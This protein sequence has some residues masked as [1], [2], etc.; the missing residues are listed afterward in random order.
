MDALHVTWVA[1]LDI[2]QSSGN[3]V[4][5][6]SERAMNMGG[7]ALKPPVGV[8]VNSSEQSV[9]GSTLR[10]ACLMPAKRGKKP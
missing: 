10:F 1:I 9:N 2:R 4:P 6:S 3:V 5:E 7:N 8:S